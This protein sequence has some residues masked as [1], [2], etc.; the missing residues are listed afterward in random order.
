MFKILCRL[1]CK[2]GEETFSI[3]DFISLQCGSAIGRVLKLWNEDGLSKMS[4]LR[5][6]K[7]VRLQICMFKLLSLFIW[8]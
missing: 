2:V 5:L 8:F 6:Y 1:S 4:V 3:G 7:Q